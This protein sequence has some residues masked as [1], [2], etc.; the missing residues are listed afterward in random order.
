MVAVWRGFVMKNK[1]LSA[2]WLMDNVGQSKSIGLFECWVP[3]Y[4]AN[5]SHEN[6]LREKEN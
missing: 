4:T 2:F 3:F 1:Y 5:I 6:D